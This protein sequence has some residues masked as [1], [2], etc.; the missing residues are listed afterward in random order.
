MTYHKNWESPQLFIHGNIEK[1]TAQ[2]IKQKQLGG[3]D[4]FGVPGIEGISI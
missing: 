3:L 2:L 1:I 4:D